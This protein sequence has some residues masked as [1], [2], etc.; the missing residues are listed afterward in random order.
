M[1]IDQQS[2][3]N[4]STL[5]FKQNSQ[6]RMIAY[7]SFV[8]FYY[9]IFDYMTDQ[10]QNTQNTSSIRSVS[11]S[12]PSPRN[13]GCMIAAKLS[14]EVDHTIL[15][16]GGQSVFSD[17]STSSDE[18]FQLITSDM[19]GWQARPDM[20]MPKPLVWFSAVAYEI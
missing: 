17:A 2:P 1:I 18:V 20:T 4:N 7:N 9:I 6:S 8:W 11:S 3:F 12:L 14:T 13:A 19:S 10:K 16:L 15:Y 5:N